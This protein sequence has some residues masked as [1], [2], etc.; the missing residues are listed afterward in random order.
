MGDNLD[1]YFITILMI[2]LLIIVSGLIYSQDHRVISIGD[3][4]IRNGSFD[5][6]LSKEQPNPDTG[7]L[8]SGGSWSFYLNNGA[9]G[10][11]EI[12]KGVLKITPVTIKAPNYGIQIIQSPVTLDKLGRYKVSFDARST[13]QRNIIVKIGGIAARGWAAYTGEKIVAISTNMENHEFE[14]TMKMNTDNTAR[15][16]FW[17]TTSIEPVWIKNV[18]V[19]KIDQGIPKKE[20][21]SGT[22]TVKDEKKLENWQL[23][24]SDEFDGKSIDTNKWSFEIGNGPLGNGWGNNEMEYYTDDPDNAFVE[25]GKLII[26]A[27]RRYVTDNGRV[28]KYTSARMIT[29]GKFSTP[30]SCRI[31]VMA[32]LPQGKGIWPAIWMLGDNFGAIPWPDCGEIDIME[33]I[34]HEPWKVYGTVHGPESAGSGIGGSFVLNEAT[35]GNRF[36]YGF[37][38]F[39]VEIKPETVEFYVDD[40]IYFIANKDKVQYD[41][42]DDEWV[43]NSP[44]FLILNLAVGG[45][46]PGNPNDTTVFPQQM[47]VDYVRV[48]TNKGAFLAEG[49]ADWDTGYKQPP[50]IVKTYPKSGMILDNAFTDPDVNWVYGSFESGEAKTG[51]NN[52]IARFD[53][54]KVGGE[55]WHIQIKTKNYLNLENGKSYIITFKARSS[56]ERKMKIVVE[57]N[58]SGWARYTEQEV[59]LTPEFKDYRLE[60]NMTRGNDHLAELVFMLG[61]VGNSGAIGKHSVEIS[62]VVMQ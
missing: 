50:G 23:M 4:I 56:I 31:D 54:Y 55:D 28:N 59:L 20:P 14:F 27:L 49:E 3:N 40:V 52:G 51:F 25:D 61:T 12:I 35:N 10:K 60:F 6:P 37:H 57:Q 47:E 58:G 5:H 45:N 9:D 30:G 43:Y 34:G 24:W 42:G 29:K 38:K 39:S 11:A 22:K 62:S 8:D 13:A 53:I 17:F 21:V 33:L 32:K 36:S 16:E 44:F 41:W 2:L 26:R 15:V 7:I 46:W 1:R 19:I 18:S 48:Y